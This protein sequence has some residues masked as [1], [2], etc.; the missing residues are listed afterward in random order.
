MHV[1][2]LCTEIFRWGKYGG[3]GRTARAVGRALASRGVRVSAVV[4]L[5]RG[6]RTPVREEFDGITVLGYPP[7]A[8]WASQDLYRQVDADLYHSIE[9][10]TGTWLA[11]RAMPDRAHVVTFQDPRLFRDWWIEFRHPTRARRQT[12]TTWLYYEN[13]MVRAAVRRCHGCSV[14]ATSLSAKAM[15]KYGL[16]REPAF[17][18]TPVAIPETVDKAARPTA[19]FVGRFDRVKRPQVF[20]DLAARCPDV[21]FVALGG[22]QDARFERE[23]MDRAPLPPNLT[24]AGFINQF[25]SDELNRHLARNWILVNTSAKEGLPNA[26]VEAAAHG[27]AIL[28]AFDPDGFA[29]R[30]GHLVTDGDYAAGLAV[31]LRDDLWRERGAA[32]RD[33]VR[34]HFAVDLVMD[35]YLDFYAAALARAGRGSVR[36]GAM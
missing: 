4:P 11:Q 1:C 15:A 10:F 27:C 33:H 18:P 12:A 21:D 14:A 16:D 5:P 36:A 34:R 19:C 31:L 28:S 13:P 2:L 25:E 8:T 9:P 6:S 20:F 17:L 30:F 35:R 23:L 32:G 3:F 7:A 26:F 22:A 24:L 29:S